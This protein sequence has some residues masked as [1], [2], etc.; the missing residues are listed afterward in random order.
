MRGNHEGV[1][2]NPIIERGLV[3]KFSD[4]KYQVKEI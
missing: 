3:R 2:N 1:R 4:G